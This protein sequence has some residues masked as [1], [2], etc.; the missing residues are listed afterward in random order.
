[1]DRPFSFEKNEKER[2]TTYFQKDKQ[3]KQDNAETQRVASQKAIRQNKTKQDRKM[4]QEYIFKTK[5]LL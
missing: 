1:M 3:D 4:R 2:N 5:N